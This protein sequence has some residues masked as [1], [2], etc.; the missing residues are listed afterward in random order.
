MSNSIHKNAEIFSKIYHNCTWGEQ[1]CEKFKGNSGFGS[2]IEFNDI[3]I[4][5]FKQY[6]E[7]NNFKSIVDLGCGDFRWMSKCLENTD[8]QYTGYDVYKE[9]I[10]HH[11]EKYNKKYNFCFL[12]FFNDTEN[13]MH[14]DVCILKDVLQHHT[15]KDIEKLLTFLINSK[16]FSVILIINCKETNVRDIETGDFRG[17]SASCYPLSQ[18]H[19]K[20]LFYYHTKEVSVIDL[21]SNII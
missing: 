2:S 3:F 12:D 15:Y 11:L 19:A 16:K 21:I 18:F 6:L 9:L 17:L 1:I 5:W 4:A 13:I 10:D 20:I 8:I 14:G 7:I